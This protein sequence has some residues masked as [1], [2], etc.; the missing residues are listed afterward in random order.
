MMKEMKGVCFLFTETGTEGGWWAIQE[1]G[2]VDEEGYWSYNGL[3]PLKNGDDFTVYAE[4]GSVL[5]HGIIHQDS[6]TGAIPHRVIRK[7]KVVIDNSWKQQVVSGFWVHWVQ[8]GMD[9]EAWGDL[10]FGDKRCL[11]RRKEKK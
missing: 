5:W 10:F 4:D 2:F 3:R 7:G 11:V 9:P 8:K 6:K 1:D